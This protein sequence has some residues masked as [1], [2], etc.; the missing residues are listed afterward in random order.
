M[1]V[2]TVQWAAAGRPWPAPRQVESISTLT[3]RLN[4]VIVLARKLNVVYCWPSLLLLLLALAFVIV[5]AVESACDGHF[6]PLSSKYQVQ[7]SQNVAQQVEFISIL[8]FW[9]QK[10]SIILDFGS[11]ADCLLGTNTI[12]R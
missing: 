7:T 5:V 3:W 1:G 10:S 6:V 9:A 11:K 2:A 4:V 8:Q 12:P